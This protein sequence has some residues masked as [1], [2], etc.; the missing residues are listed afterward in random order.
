MALAKLTKRVRGQDADTELVDMR[1]EFAAGNRQPLAR[2]LLEAV[3]KTL[4]NE[5]QVILYLNRR[6]MSTFVM[7]K[8]CGKSVQCLGCSV[9]LVQHAEIDGLVCHYCGYARQMPTTCDHCGSRNIR[10]LGMGTQ[11]L[12]TMVKK[13]W[14][15][16]RVR[17]VRDVTKPY[18]GRVDRGD[19]ERQRDSTS[20]CT[21]RLE[22][23]DD[24][25]DLARLAPSNQL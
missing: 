19:A 23:G 10:A 11:R 25:C 9:S 8:E 4:A 2:R 20:D 21:R 18:P 15:Q 16:A 22:L 1:D 17:A 13:L 14:P 5:E 3:D 6:G 24:P 12:E 7:C